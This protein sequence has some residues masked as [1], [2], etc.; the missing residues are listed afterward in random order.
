[1]HIN[2]F[3]FIWF[4]WFELA[5]RKRNLNQVNGMFDDDIE[6]SSTSEDYAEHFPLFKFHDAEY[7]QHSL[8]LRLC[9]FDVP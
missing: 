9:V 1:M 3:T 2:I 8:H 7:N 5:K 4:I 6:V